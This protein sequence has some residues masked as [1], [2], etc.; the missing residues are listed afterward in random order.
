MSL[1]ARYAA[2][3]FTLFCWTFHSAVHDHGFARALAVVS[4]V[5][6]L[7]NVLDALLGGDE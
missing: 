7:V 2:V 5:L 3:A 1:R 6:A 4:S